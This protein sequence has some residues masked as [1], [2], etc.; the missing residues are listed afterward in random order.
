MHIKL[1]KEDL[2]KLIALL[3]MK[4]ENIAIASYLNDLCFS[5]DSFNFDTDISKCN[6][7]T[8]Y[9]LCLNAFNDYF[10]LDD[11]NEENNAIINRHLGDTFRY[12]NLEEFNQNPYKKLV[13][14][15]EICFQG[16]KL[17]YLKYPSLSFF[18]LDDISVNKD[19]LYL[20]KTTIGISN[21]TY[22]FL[23]LSKNNNIWMCITPN[24][25][26]TMEPHLKQA[27]GNIVTFGLGLGYYAFMAA[28]KKEVKSITIIERDE[29]IINLFT[30]H[31]LSLFPNKDKIHIINK[32][33]IQYIKETHLSSYDY[34]FFDLW[35]NAEDGLPL[36]LEINRHDIVP[37]KSFWIEESLICMYRRC[38]LTVIE[39]SLN[40]YNDD[41]YRKAKNAID[42]IINEI[43]FK[44]KN[45]KFNSYEEIYKFISR[46][47]IYRL[48]RGK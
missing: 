34:A 24:E 12:V 13:N 25:I 27:K 29:N 38:L 17:H 28:N 10:E 14:P 33:A 40:G 44:T 11:T 16:Y 35:H 9:N 47:N 37:P 30:Q 20:E 32:D 46:D 23:T 4:E 6:E 31:L 41:D 15:K 22:Q 26:N 5:L 1:S 3:E 43:Y 8:L 19:H 7:K 2:N 42:K 18:P 36:Y 39:E 45:I 21:D 48:I